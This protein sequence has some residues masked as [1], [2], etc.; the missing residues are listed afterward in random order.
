MYLESAECQV[1]SQTLTVT[2]GD[3]VRTDL[4]REVQAPLM[5][6]QF[7]QGFGD[8]R[9]G[10]GDGPAA[11]SGQAPERSLRGESGRIGGPEHHVLEILDAIK[12]AYCDSVI[13][14]KSVTVKM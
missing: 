1:I 11:P 10:L 6:G 14:G 2:S 4:H 9:G 3:R 12:S 5:T 13:H 7:L 8:Q